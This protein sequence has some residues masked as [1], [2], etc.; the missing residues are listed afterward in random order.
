MA[1]TPINLTRVSDNMRTLSL[2][3]SLRN[4]TLQIFLDQGR[5]ASGNRFNA[6]SENPVL[7][8]RAMHLS[9]LLEQQDQILANISH[10]DSL[11]ATSDTAIGEVSSLLTEAHD[12]ALTMINSTT[13]SAERQAEAQLVLGIIDQLVTVGNR[14]YGDI[15][16]F[17]GQ[18]TQQPPFTQDHGVAEYRGD[19]GALR[20][21]VDYSQDPIINMTGAELFGALAG[22]LQ[23]YVDLN[24]ALTQETRLADAA[25]TGAKP[26]QT[27]PIR[28][29]LTDPAISFIADL[30]SADTA[31]NVIDLLNQAAADAGLSVGP[32]AAFHAAFNAAGNG[33]QITA[34]TGTVTIGEV[35]DGMTAR[36]LGLLGSGAAIVG[37][38]LR[39]R[40]TAMTTIDALFGG[41]GA[42]LGLIRIE[43][44][45]MAVDVDLST[46]RTVGELMNRINAAGVDVQAR[47]NDAGTGI[48][49]L[50]LV[51]GMAMKIGEVDGDTANL[52]GIR[53]LH[54]GTRLS[55]L[56]QGRGVQIRE[57]YDDLS[58]RTH[59]GVSFSVNL[60]GCETIG[61]VLERINGA[62][63]E[64]GA[65]LTAS[66]ASVGNGIRIEDRTAGSLDLVVQR[67]DLSY[68][69]DGLGIEKTTGG[70][71]IIGDDTS[72][73]IPQSVFTALHDL[74]RGLMGDDEIMIGDA[75][76]RLEQFM[77]RASQLQGEVGARS[78]AMHTRLAFTED[79][80]ASTRALLS[81]VKDLDYAEA[82][83]RFQMAQT[84]LQANLLTGSRLMQ[85]S[86]LNF[87]Q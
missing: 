38:D 40:L 67:A 75:G 61:D 13:S 49:V 30:S 29:T 19:L 16:L 36:D 70:S 59:S 41:T 72:G 86:L 63:A 58:I 31:G 79:A 42:D 1:I 14:R 65:D 71:E 82:I 9:D 17:G 57:G 12:I 32:G 18:Q 69:I 52:L 44:G 53:S 4:N 56:N 8:S 43:N 81:E 39:P 84:T 22:G 35:G 85:M 23:G 48:D 3:D 74:Y 62:A 24:P 83:T 76:A 47:I 6:P 34:G 7:A 28:V 26:I 10:A 25:G 45:H 2:L 50:N 66:L 15:H 27:G 60:D 46:V 80:V 20:A 55:T 78:K 5:L 77:G 11:L 33:Y 37:A 21:H 51:S 64:A 73:I 68:A 54:A 87:I